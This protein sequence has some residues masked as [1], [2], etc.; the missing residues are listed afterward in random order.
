MY[1]AT[2]STDSTVKIFDVRNPSQCLVTLSSNTLNADCTSVAF[3]P[4]G[5]H[6]ISG[7][8]DGQSVIWNVVSSQFTELMTKD[9]AISAISFS[10]DGKFLAASS[11]DGSTNVFVAEEESY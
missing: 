3:S 6:V 9:K 1:L 10:E 8:N 5:Y 2:G 11:H 4:K 7:F